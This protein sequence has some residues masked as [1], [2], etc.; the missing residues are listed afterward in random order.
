MTFGEFLLVVDSFAVDEEL[1]FVNVSFISQRLLYQY[2]LHW[3]R[4]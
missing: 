3:L 1:Y 4:H 2:R